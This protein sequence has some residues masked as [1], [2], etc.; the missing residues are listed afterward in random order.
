MVHIEQKLSLLT[1]LGKPL[2]HFGTRRNV[3]FKAG[4]GSHKRVNSEV[5]DATRPTL[6]VKKD[7]ETGA[8]TIITSHGGGK[9]IRDA[10]AIQNLNVVHEN[11]AYVL[12]TKTR[13][14]SSEQHVQPV[15]SI[16][17]LERALSQA[18]KDTR[19]EH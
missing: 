16:N 19:E 8:M 17:T 9:I 18:A 6:S 2:R 13:Q 10:A 15:I 1:V 14:C 11:G 3:Q 4:D 7:A 12:E 5:T